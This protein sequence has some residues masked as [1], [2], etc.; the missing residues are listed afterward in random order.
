MC[1]SCHFWG[2]FSI[3]RLWD[4]LQFVRFE[5]VKSHHEIKKGAQI[6]YFTW[7]LHIR[8]DTHRNLNISRPICFKKR[9]RTFLKII[10]AQISWKNFFSKKF[11]SRTCDC[12]TT[13]LDLLFFPKKII[14]LFKCDYSIFNII[15]KTCFKNVFRKTEKLVILLI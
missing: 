11:F 12:K 14:L 3:C 10:S 9:F 15:L 7:T 8:L 4:F 1:K 6:N 2:F 13:A 5:N